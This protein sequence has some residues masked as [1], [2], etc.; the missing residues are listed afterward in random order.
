M[1]LVVLHEA[2]EELSSAALWY[3]E[4]RAGLVRTC[5]RKLLSR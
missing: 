5:S 2:S 4:E 1:K 3:E